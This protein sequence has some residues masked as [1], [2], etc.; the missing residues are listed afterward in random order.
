MKQTIAGNWL[1]E[2]RETLLAKDERLGY[3]EREAALAE[4]S[5]RA[6]SVPAE[7]R[8]ARAFESVCDKLKPVVVF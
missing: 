7:E 2:I 1:E 8:M 5:E 6:D 4:F 3:I